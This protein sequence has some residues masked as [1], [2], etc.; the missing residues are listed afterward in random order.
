[1]SFLCHRFSGSVLSK[2]FL[3]LYSWHCLAVLKQK[4]PELSS[5]SLSQRAGDLSLTFPHFLQNI[6]VAPFFFLLYNISCSQSNSD[7]TPGEI[8]LHTLETFVP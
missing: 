1:M 4:S 8:L 5:L 3:Q 7:F 6:T 2:K